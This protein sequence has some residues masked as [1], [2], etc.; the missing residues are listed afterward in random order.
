MALVLILALAGVGFNIYNI[1]SLSAMETSNSITINVIILIISLLL[2]L[3]AISVMAFSKYVV[4]KDGV[5]CFFGVIPSKYK[6]NE[7]IQF[8][9]FKKSDKLVAYFNDEKYTVIVIN[10]AN[11][12]KFVSVVRELNPKIVFQVQEENFQD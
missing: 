3:F 2:T 5:Y 11:Y 10:P 9:H 4:A 8:T 7:I 12:D 6:A 1:V